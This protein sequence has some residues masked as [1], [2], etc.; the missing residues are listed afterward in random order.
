MSRTAGA[1]RLSLILGAILLAAA[2]W[3]VTS[4]RALLES[5]CQSLKHP[6]AGWAVALP[7]CIL[8]SFAST[9][10]GL[11]WL[12]NRVTPLGIVGWGE[13]F[14]LTLAS[15]LGNLVP[16][17]AGM[18][19][20][21]A[22]LHRVHRIPVTVS[23]LLTVQSTLLTMAST[24][25][26]GIALLLVRLGGLSWLAVPASVLL[27]AALI[28]V[29]PTGGWAFR[30][31]FT[32]R[33]LDTLLSAVRTG[34]AFELVGAPISPLAALAFALAAQMANAVPM[35]GSGLGIREWAVALLA[36]AVAGLSTQEA[37]AAELVHRA[38]EIMLIVPSGLIA[39][40]P[41][42][43]R[44]G[45]AARPRSMHGEPTAAL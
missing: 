24:V 6:P 12:T 38:A 32:S 19:G 5:A 31:A 1:R 29:G 8:A 9:A 3:S 20:R 25:W 11:R 28:G 30:A 26:L 7:V 40:V 35:I 18:A 44:F 45:Q 14:Q 37:L 22:Y 16:M 2:V 4:N 34:A 17:Q 23:V 42:A 15:S 21:I 33:L 27:P 10:A 36:P 41:L 39:S 43:R 13:M